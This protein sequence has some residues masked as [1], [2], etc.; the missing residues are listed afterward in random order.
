MSVLTLIL[1]ELGHEVDPMPNDTF[2]FLKEGGRVLDLDP[3][4]LKNI[5]LQNDLPHI[6]VDG[7]MVL[8]GATVEMAR[9]LVDAWK[10]RPRMSKR[11]AH[12]V[13]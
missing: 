8:P 10:N 12:V 6:W 1:S 4:T 3:G 5:V 7:R 13:S 11:P 2:H 9:P